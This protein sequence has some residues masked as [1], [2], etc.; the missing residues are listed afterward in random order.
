MK[1]FETLELYNT[2]KITDLRT[3]HYNSG[4]IILFAHCE[5]SEATSSLQRDIELIQAKCLQIFARF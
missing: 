3:K 4:G 2:E 5:I 1:E